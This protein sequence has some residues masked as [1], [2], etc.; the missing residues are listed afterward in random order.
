MDIQGSEYDALSGMKNFLKSA[1][2]I[3][4][5]CEYENHLQAMGHS[6]EQLDELILSYGFKYVG[7]IGND[8]IFHK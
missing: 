6:F 3:Y 8:K 4:L 7:K 2:D 5:L 1:N